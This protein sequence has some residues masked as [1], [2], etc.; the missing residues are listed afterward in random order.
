MTGTVTRAPGRLPLRGL[1]LA[2]AISLTGTRISTIAIPWFVLVSTGSATQTGLVAAVEMTPLVL[3]KVLGGPFTD[4]YGGRRISVVCDAASALVVGAV[5]LL[6]HLDRLSLPV[7]LV[8]IGLAG[9]LRGPG[10]GAKQALLPGVA[11]AARHPME[12]VTGLAGAVERTASMAGAALAGL[13][14][15]TLGAST[16]LY[17]DAASFA[18]CA[19]ILLATTGA[20]PKV[21][22]ETRDP[23]PYLRQLGSGWTFLRHDTVLLGMSIMVAVT[24]LLD[25]AASAVLMPVWA[26]ETGNGAAALG[27][28]FAIWSAASV[29]SSLVAARWAHRIPRFRTYVLAFTLTCSRFVVLAVGLPL[30]VCAAVFVVGGF[31]S[32]FLNPILGAV[33]FERIPPH[34]V[35]RVSAMNSALC[36]SLMPLGGLLGGALATYAGVRAGLL[37]VAAG[38]LLATLSPLVIPSFR[39]FDRRTDSSPVAVAVAPAPG[40]LPTLR[41]P[42]SCEGRSAPAR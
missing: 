14:I 15:A 26:R 36:W 40:A 28:L 21:D 13:L 29:A 16:A 1:L 19:L 38:Y 27:L 7:L 20:L 6:H 41:E 4:R 34:L 31:S 30:W 11:A 42:V 10:D 5:P 25:L 24:N 3:F 23:A 2:E 8:L 32:G 22:P 39:Q 33:V 35:G 9:A 17:V 37:V 18:V 12:R